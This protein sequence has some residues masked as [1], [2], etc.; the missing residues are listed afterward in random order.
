M[1]Q[2]WS[3][4]ALFFRNNFSLSKI[5][6]AYF[7]SPAHCLFNFIDKFANPVWQL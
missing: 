1:A 6:K 5:R 4:T 3:Q 2:D 7:I